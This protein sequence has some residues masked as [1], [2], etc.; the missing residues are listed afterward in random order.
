[1]GDTVTRV[2]N[3]TSGT[4]RG[5]EGEDGLDGNVEGG[6]VEG[7]E[8]D[9][10][11]LFTIGLWVERSLGQEN[12]VFLGGDSKLIVEGVMPARAGGNRQRRRR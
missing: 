12:G 3:D 1:M 7:L 9:L 5:V 4:S 8:H 6:D 10:G 2:K 11:H